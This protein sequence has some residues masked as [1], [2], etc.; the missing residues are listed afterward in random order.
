MSKI[1]LI[2]SAVKISNSNIKPVIFVV[3]VWKG[4]IA[5]RRTRK[6][7]EDEM[8]FI[9]MVSSADSCIYL[10]VSLYI[11]LSHCVSCYFLFLCLS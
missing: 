1:L 9:R 7:R 5:R 4:F 6:E 3:Q 11:L 2:I 8:I 10:V